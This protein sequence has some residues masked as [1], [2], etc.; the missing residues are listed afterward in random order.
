LRCKSLIAGTRVPDHS[1][2]LSIHIYEF[3][4]TC[5]CTE[6]LESGV[7]DELAILAKVKLSRQNSVGGRKG[8]EKRKKSWKA[9]GEGTSGSPLGRKKNTD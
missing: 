3:K 7:P 1:D 9:V 6:S 8:G 4:S 2:F 5:R